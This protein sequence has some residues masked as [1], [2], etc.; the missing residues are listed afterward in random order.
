MSKYKKYF[1]INITNIDFYCV[2]SNLRY[3]S[4]NMECKKYSRDNRFYLL[5]NAFIL[6]I[7]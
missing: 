4:L 6:F 1:Q 3:G 7:L 5:R 2:T